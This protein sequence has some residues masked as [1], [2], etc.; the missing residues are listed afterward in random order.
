VDS[1]K[2]PTDRTVVAIGTSQVIFSAKKVAARSSSGN[3][4]A[5]CANDLGW[6]LRHRSLWVGLGSSPSR[7]EREKVFASGPADRGRG[8]D[9]CQ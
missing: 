7:V 4:S 2:N 8:S 1:A 9:C 5:V 3:R 6:D